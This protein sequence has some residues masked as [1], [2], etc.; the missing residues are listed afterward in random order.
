MVTLGE[1][2]KDEA[3]GGGLLFLGLAMLFV[4]WAPRSGGDVF[5][6]TAFLLSIF[7][8]KNSH[9]HLF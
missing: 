1:V 6:Y 8:V 7:I 4:V 3:A 9:D 5:L 2:G